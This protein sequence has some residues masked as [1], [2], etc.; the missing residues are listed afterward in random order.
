ME[1][2]DDYVREPDEQ[3]SERLVQNTL[4][5][6]PPERP[7]TR[8]ERRRRRRRNNSFVDD[9]AQIQYHYDTQSSSNELVDTEHDLRKAMEESIKNMKE[10]EEEQLKIL[11]QERIEEENRYMEEQIKRIEEQELLEQQRKEEEEK[12]EKMERLQKR[13]GIIMAVYRRYAL[14][15]PEHQFYIVLNEW[16]K[17]LNSK[18]ELNDKQTQWLHEKKNQKLRNMLKEDNCI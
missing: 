16:I 3:I 6:F 7:T 14:D 1:N 12:I 5:S 2:E 17:Q 11:E 4:Y 9:S 8:Q 15:T 10:K 18:L 13:Y